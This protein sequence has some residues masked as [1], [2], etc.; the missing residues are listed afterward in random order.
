[1]LSLFFGFLG[2]ML[3]EVPFAK[4]EKMMFSVFLKKKEKGPPKITN[5]LNS[6]VGTN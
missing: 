5:N 4:L 6:V 2:T 1:M 3:V